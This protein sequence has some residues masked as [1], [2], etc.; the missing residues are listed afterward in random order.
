MRFFTWIPVW[1]RNLDVFKKLFLVN[2]FLPLLEPL[3]Y[4]FAFGFGLGAMVGEVEGLPYKIFILPAIVAMATLNASFFYTTYSSFVKMIFQKTFDAI[5]ATPLSIEDVVVGEIMWG[6]TRGMISGIMVL[7]LFLILKLITIKIAVLYLPLIIILSF[8]FSSLGMFFTA[9][10]NNIE[11][12][13]YPIFLYFTPM[14][15]FSGTFFPVSQLPEWL[16][17]VSLLVF[18]LT[19]MLKS[20]RTPFTVFDL[21]TYFLSFLTIIHGLFFFMISIKLMRRKLIK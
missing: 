14:L 10:V 18:P 3:F 6:A 2:F 12:F 21:K 4:L 13:N 8:I 16:R 5:I 17:F 1:R 15:F 7:V 9:V 19:V 11:S 20:F